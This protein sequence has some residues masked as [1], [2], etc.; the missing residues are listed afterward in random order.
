MVAPTPAVFY[1]KK[2]SPFGYS[3]GY[4]PTYHA[5][6]DYPWAAGT[7]IP[8]PGA[9]VVVT[10][11]KSVDAGNYITLRINGKYVLIYHME[12]L[13]PLRG[14]DL[15]AYGS[16]LGPVGSTGKTKGAHAHVAVSTSISPGQGVRVDPVPHIDSWIRANGGSFAGGDTTPIIEEEEEDIMTYVLVNRNPGDSLPG[17]PANAVFIGSGTDPLIWASNFG[18]EL[19]NG[20]VA[21]DSNHTAIA[22]RISQVGLRGSGVAINKVYKSMADAR[23]DKP[24]YILGGGMVAGVD[25]APILAALAAIKASIDAAP[26]SSLSAKVIAEA[27]ND[28]A[29]MRMKE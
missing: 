17:V 22:E 2:G 26:A 8:S 20:V 4:G 9:G 16:P 7:I 10:V 14:G 28:D 29:A 15:V 19:A 21:A 5:G 3:A 25:N 11:A 13:S 12:S 23:D 18:P 1:A 6:Q 27:V 24:A